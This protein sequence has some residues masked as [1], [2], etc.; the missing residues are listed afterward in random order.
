MD[1]GLSPDGVAELLIGRRDQ[2]REQLDADA[3]RLRSVEAR[4]RTIEKENPVNTF[5]ETPLPQLR[6]VQLSARIE[7]MS[8]IEE[9][10]GGM[11]GRV[12]ALIDAA[13]VDRVGPGI[14]TYTTDGDGMVAAAAEQIGAAPVPAG[15]DAAVVPPQQRALTTR[16]VGDD[17][18][19]IQQAWQA[20]VA[21]V[22][23][24][25]L[26]P[27]GTCREVYER[28]PFDGPAGGWVVDLQQPVA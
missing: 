5:T 14:A 25:G 24:R 11:F 10:I 23:A 3:R 21:E 2:L 8:E 20:L 6:L 12:N 13:G 22:E 9:E 16:Y 27:Q 18:S 4:L 15:L 26:V 7:E 19:G 17:L 1:G 28:T